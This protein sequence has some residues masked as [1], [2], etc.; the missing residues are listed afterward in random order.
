MKK[1]IVLLVL[2]ALSFNVVNAANTLRVGNPRF[3]WYTYQGT[4]EEATLSIKPKGIYYQYDLYLTFSARGTSYTSNDSLEVV[5][6]FDLPENSIINDS[7][8]WLNDSTIIKARIMDKWSATAIYEGIVARRQDPSLLTKT[9]NTH[10]ELRVFPMAG[11]TTRKV[12]ISYLVAADWNKKNVSAKLPTELLT[13]S[14]NTVPKLS[15]ITWPGAEWQNPQIVGYPTF[16]FNQQYTNAQFG[17]YRY[18]EITSSYYNSSLSFSYNSPMVNGVYLNKYQDLSEN[19]YQMVL[20]P[21]EIITNVPKKKVVFL[22]DYDETKTNVT[23]TNLLN[24]L[25]NKLINQLSVSDSFNLM[26]S[27][28]VIKKASLNW[29]PG[30]SISIENAFATLTNQLAD[31]S[32]LS[33][34]IGEGI[35]FIGSHGNSGKI[36]LLSDADQYGSSSVAN[37][38][39]NDIVGSMNPDIPFYIA[40]FQNLNYSNNYIN[41]RYY[42]GNEYFYSNL[43]TITQGSY[44]RTFNYYYYGT[45]SNNYTVSDVINLNFDELSGIISAFNLY[46]SMTG[47]YCHSRYNL[48]AQSNTAYLNKP[49]L[50]TGKYI[51]TFPFSVIVSG[52]YN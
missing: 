52:D 15:V 50:Q 28:F 36:M 9:S 38:L 21:S 40:D 42:Y 18:T 16:N 3:S 23:K 24:E 22:V 17:N 37:N 5:F 35:S 20:L 45:S 1:V 13:T 48:N 29:I 44:F 19:Y 49:I 6:N 10:Y 43:S 39:V 26:Y 31:Y 41:G 32:N 8:L 14:L 47:G 12:K 46:T 7:W 33:P 51:G 2:L 27:N 4:I 30:D 11:G 34:L 25:K